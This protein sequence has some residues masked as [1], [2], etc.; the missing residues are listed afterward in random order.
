V[1]MS[2]SP[3]RSSRLRRW[4]ST[5]MLVVG[6]VLLAGAVAYYAYTFLAGRGAGGLVTTGG[7]AET[8]STP[9]PAGPG[10]QAGAWASL[11]P[12]SQLPA[13]QWADP[14]GT[15]G[16]AVP[17][18][19]TLEGF[20]P[21][22]PLGQPSLSG[23]VGQAERII[24]PAIGVDAA[25]DEL[26]ILDLGDSS[27]YETPKFMVGHIPATPN[28]GSHGNGWYFGHL[29]S[30][31]LGEGNVFAALPQIPGLLRAGE[32]VHVI[33]QTGSRQ[34]LYQVSGTGIVPAE[35]L[36][37]TQAGDARLTLVTCYPRLKYDQRLLVS[38]VLTGFRDVPAS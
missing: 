6:L 9:T 22:S 33:L 25:V 27:A 12:G 8:L 7:P 17:G 34:Y 18:A 13:R 29:E 31:V 4:A 32:D 16:F 19:G 20:I 21:L 14:R 24:I 37:L 5:G 23:A 15:L 36:E 10:S 1:V 26:A 38:A 28:P 3:Q 11:Y 35:A 2:P 30:P